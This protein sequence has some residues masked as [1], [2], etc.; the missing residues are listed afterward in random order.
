MI[1]LRIDAEQR[2]DDIT[3]G[4]VKGAVREADVNAG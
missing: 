1:P 2:L 4:E 3:D